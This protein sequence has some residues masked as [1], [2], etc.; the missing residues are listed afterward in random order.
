MLLASVGL[1]ARFD[2][3]SDLAQIYGLGFSLNMAVTSICYVFILL[4]YWNLP[5]CSF[6][7][8]SFIVIAI[9]VDGWVVISNLLRMGKGVEKPLILGFLILIIMCIWFRGRTLLQEAAQ[10]ESISMAKFKEM[11]AKDQY[12]RV[13]G[14]GIFFTAAEGANVPTLVSQLI[15]KVQ[16]LPQRCVFVNVK[17]TEIPSV[18]P[19]PPLSTPLHLEPLGH[20]LYKA[21]VM[22]G[23]GVTK[24]YAHIIGR[25]ILTLLNSLDEKE[26]ELQGGVP[27]HSPS[28]SI[29]YGSNAPSYS[30][31]STASSWASS[32]RSTYLPLIQ[33]EDDLGPSVQEG[34]GKSKAGSVDGSYREPSPPSQ[35]HDLITYFI[36]RDVIH[37]KR[38]STKLHRWLLRFYNYLAQNSRN[39]AKLY[40]IPPDDLIEIGLRWAL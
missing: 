31:P 9:I 7:V 27:Q 14:L 30:T 5:A 15:K 25:D 33:S 37:P 35:K 23:Y 19:K 18:T 11:I 24:I 22:F 38:P 1:L 13:P 12:P 3:A 21:T 39:I 29:S 40:H 16:T 4:K 6:K 26:L 28:L 36:G 10:S 2:E 32:S 8:L 17:I 34:D 20:G